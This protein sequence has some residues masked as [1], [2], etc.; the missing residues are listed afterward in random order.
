[1]VWSS[2]WQEEGGQGGWGA[3][4]PRQRLGHRKAVGV[5]VDWQHKAG[6]SF[7]WIVP[8]HGIPNHM[9]EA[10]AHGGDVYVHWQ[11][12]QDPRPGAVVSFWPYVDEQ[13]LGAEEC[14]NRSVL[15]FAVPADSKCALTLPMNEVNPC[16]SYLPSSLFF[17]EL[18]ERGVTLRKYL[19]NS[20]FTLFELWGEPQDVVLV[21]DEI[22]LLSHQEA[23]VLLSRSMA[24][25]VQPDQLCELSG[26]D[27]P[28]VPPRCRLATSL[29]P[30]GASDAEQ[31]RQRLFGILGV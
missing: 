18:E 21:A 30:D 4:G 15:R 31:A 1:M 26:E 22:G 12:I 28:N 19:W 27:L 16:A 25:N 10:H 20:P 13:G 7:G 2:S 8:I 3:P 14:V 24:G 5:L 17:P 11:D 9:P 6:K 23:K 29:C